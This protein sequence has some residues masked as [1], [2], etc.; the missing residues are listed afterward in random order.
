MTEQERNDLFNKFLKE[1]SGLIFLDPGIEDPS[2]S[3]REAADLIVEEAHLMRSGRRGEGFIDD[4]HLIPITGI[5]RLLRAGVDGESLNRH[6]IGDNYTHTVRYKGYT[7][8]SVTN[9][10]YDFRNRYA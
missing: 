4:K 5:E 1:Y 7:F 8:I 6:T 10:P 2:I 9:K 3:D